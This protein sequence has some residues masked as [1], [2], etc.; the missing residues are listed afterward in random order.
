MDPREALLLADLERAHLAEI[1]HDDVLQTLGT[2][3]LAADTCLQA[4]DRGR[5]DRLGE[6][7]AK[8]HALLGEA[9]SRLRQLM[10]ELRPYDPS[11]GGLEAALRRAAGAHGPASLSECVLDV[12]IPHDLNSTVA[13]LAYRSVL[14]SLRSIRNPSQVDRVLIKLRTGSRG[15]SIHVDFEV[16]ADFVNDAVLPTSRV[17]FLRWRTRALGG[18]FTEQRRSPQSISLRFLLPAS[19]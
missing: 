13:A 3:L 7:L 4:W 14:E 16:A 18:S 10:S 2:G 5:T 1:I 17:E 9:A 8:L 6:Q 11:D 19:A 15:L 12:K